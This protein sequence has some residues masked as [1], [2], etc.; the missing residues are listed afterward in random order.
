MSY[1]FEVVIP[2]KA[3]SSQSKGRKRTS[4]QNDLQEFVW[5]HFR[6]LYPSAPSLPYDRMN[7]TGHSIVGLVYYFPVDYTEL[8]QTD[9]LTDSDN[10]N[11]PVWDALQG[12]L[13]RDDKIVSIRIAGVLGLTDELHDNSTISEQAA[14][15]INYHAAN[16]EPALY[17]KMQTIVNHHI[18]FSI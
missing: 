17:L 3:K 8:Y 11:K 2:T 16:N 9:D 13:Y 10:I 6:T 5:N 1:D 14:D 7:K 18:P 15:Q 4:Y 12:H